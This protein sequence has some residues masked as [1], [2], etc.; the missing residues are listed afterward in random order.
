[1]CKCTSI[2]GSRAEELEEKVEKHL[3]N[4]AESVT[5]NSVKSKQ[6]SKCDKM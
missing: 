3:K 1:M 5:L 6:G 4:L 2:D